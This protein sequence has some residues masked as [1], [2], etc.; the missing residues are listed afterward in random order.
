[1]EVYPN[2]VGFKDGQTKQLWEESQQYSQE[3]HRLYQE[4]KELMQKG[5]RELPSR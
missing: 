2:E 1:M 5:K 3:A 4:W